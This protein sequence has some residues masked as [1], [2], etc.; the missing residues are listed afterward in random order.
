MTSPRVEI[1]R[2]ILAEW[3]RGD[4]DALL[5]RATEDLEW[6]PV[7]V[8]A[9]EGETFHGHDGF[10]QFLSDWGSTWESWDLEPEE[11]RELGD[12]VLVLTRVRAKGRGSGVEFDQSLGHLFE[13]RGELICRGETFLDRDKALQVAESR[14]D[15]V[16]HG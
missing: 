6:H 16:E 7:L 14:A 8:E 12:Q 9:L 2:E 1:V 13:F 10:R 5:A 3:N 4:V 11:M 15:R